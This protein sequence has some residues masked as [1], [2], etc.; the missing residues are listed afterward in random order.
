MNEQELIT[1]ADRSIAA[2]NTQ[3]VDRVLACYTDDLVYRDPHIRGAIEGRDAMRRYLDRL[4]GGWNMAWTRRGV[5][6]FAGGDGCVVLWR[7]RFRRAASAITVEIG[8][9]DLVEVR[10]DRICRNEVYFDRTAL[11]VF[12]I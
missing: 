2:W 9:M 3:D 8:G 4:F 7:A 10:G 1:L 5:H 12:E 6:L 11:A